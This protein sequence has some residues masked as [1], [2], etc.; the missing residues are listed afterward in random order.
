M[1]NLIQEKTKQ[2]VSILHEMDI[3]LWI[4]FV[5][6]TSAGGDPVLPLIYGHG[7]TWQSAILISKTGE[8]I[9]IVGQFEENT[10]RRTNA[11]DKILPYNESI[12]PHLL[13]EIDRITPNRIALNFSEADVFS[14]GLSVGL[15]QVLL[16]YLKNRP[17]YLD[18]IVSA[19]NIIGAL[20]GRKTNAEL[21]R[22]RTA[23]ETTDKIYER[24][25]QLIKPGMSEQQ[26]AAIMHTQVKELDLI[27]AWDW[28][29]CPTVNAGAD[30]PAGHVSPTEI[31]LKPGDLL[32]FDFGVEE[33]NYCS[34]IQRLAY[35]PSST[36]PSPPA[37]MRRAFETVVLAIQNS[38]KAIKPGT[39]GKDIDSIA[40]STLTNEG[41][42]EFKHATGHQVGRQT[43][44]GG[45]IIG[46]LWERY[47]ETPNWPLEEGQIFTIEPSII[48]PDHGVVALEEMI[49]VTDT[50]CE[51]L[52][53]P[54]TELI[55]LKNE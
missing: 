3:D 33:N 51:F 49:R 30:S 13:K 53:T 55:L 17:Q 7:L 37:E 5:R 47:G 15:Y 4:T 34:D 2:A 18:R 39:L 16:G 43:H 32:H 23:I 11:F 27:P 41:Y 52:S 29:H 19:E 21:E 45:A 10:A 8:R 38:T 24:T 35:L 20:R 12:K 1:D 44:D 14:D 26:I 40:R 28:D 25:M 50:G 9:A 31:Q 6:E 46:P 22:I 48:H 36:H 42:D 54:Q